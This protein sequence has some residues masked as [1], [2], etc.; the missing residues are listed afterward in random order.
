VS[1][2]TFPER[3]L[4]HVVAIARRQDDDHVILADAL[5]GYAWPD[6]GL[7]RSDP[8]AERWVERFVKAQPGGGAMPIP[9]GCGCHAGRCLICN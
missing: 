8:N 9:V 4:N 3:V 1:E 6:G 7:D 5:H 2:H